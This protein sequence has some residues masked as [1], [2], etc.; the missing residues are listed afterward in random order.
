MRSEY[1]VYIVIAVGA[2]YA[3]SFAFKGRNSASRMSLSH[4]EAK[5][6]LRELRLGTARRLA[7]L[8]AQRRRIIDDFARKADV[9]RAAK[10]KK[11]IETI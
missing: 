1:L 9:L 8:R 6:K 10:V 7:E 2:A 11:D 3:V 4:E 5:K